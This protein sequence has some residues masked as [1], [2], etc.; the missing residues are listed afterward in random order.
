MK[1]SLIGVAGVI[2][3]RLGLFYAGR[4]PVG[5]D[6]MLV[7]FLAIVTIVFFVG[8]GMLSKDARTSFPHLMREGFKSAAV[9]ALIYGI[10]IL[11]YY[12]VVEPMHFA[13]RVNEMVQRGVD[14]GQPED[15]I[16]PRMEQFFTPFNYASMTFFALLAVGGFNALVVGLLH[17]KVLRRF[18]R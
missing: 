10:F 18:R 13:E 16:R 3:L 7:H 5:T 14:Q 15:V 1:L 12:R 4:P 6:F 11:I 9:Y 17:H 2:A 8:H